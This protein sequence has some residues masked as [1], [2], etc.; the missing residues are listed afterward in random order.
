[1]I[2]TVTDLTSLNEDTHYQLWQ[3]QLLDEM[4][5]GRWALQTS[6]VIQVNEA[7]WQQLLDNT[8]VQNPVSTEVDYSS[9][10]SQDTFAL[11]N[12]PTQAN[13]TAKV[14]SYHYHSKASGQNS[15]TEQLTSQ[16]QDVQSPP[17]LTHIIAQRF[18]IQAIVFNDWVLL[19]DEAA[20]SD[21]RQLTL[22]QQLQS[23]LKVTAAN[24]RF[25]LLDERQNFP[26]SSFA[27]MHNQQMAMAG[28]LG[29]LHK[30]TQSHQL[31][32]YRVGSLSQL[33]SSL[34]SQSI[35]RLPYL[36]EMLENYQLKRQ[37]WQTLMQV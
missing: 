36:Q 24:F 23:Q 14:E 33:P 28:F 12:M 29:F 32:H 1:M 19:V 17:Q 18:A 31:I 13:I 20:L 27:V 15:P 10:P 6:P 8:V 35:E 4:G 26:T 16:P 30:I 37:L 5:I 3:T 22:W 7:A 21:A 25:P 34:D 11:A 2:D 9:Q